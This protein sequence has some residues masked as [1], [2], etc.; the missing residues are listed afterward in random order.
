MTHCW[1]YDL[2]L[3]LFGSVAVSFR[4][5]SPFEIDLISVVDEAI[6]GG[7]SQRRIADDFMPVL[8]G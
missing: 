8:D 7:V 2:G 1:N 5:D 3:R 4:M 6:E